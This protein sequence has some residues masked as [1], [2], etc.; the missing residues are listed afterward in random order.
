MNKKAITMSIGMIVMLIISV[1]IFIMAVTLLFKWFA[2]A[3]ELKAEIDR[4]TKEQIMQAL[5]IGNQLVAIP[6]AIQKTRRSNAVAFGIGVRNIKDAGDFSMAIRFSGAYTPEGREICKAG[7][8]CAEYIDEKWLGNFNVID[9][10]RLKKNE[11]TVKETSIYAHS[12]ISEGISTPRGDYAFN[13][14][15]YNQG[16]TARNEPPAA[17]NIGQFSLT[18]GG[19]FYTKKI[20]QVVLKII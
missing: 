6:V 20:Y 12:S 13:V 9:T 7:Q 17:C 14:C 16:L 10:F 19:D 5:R 8:T 1:L 2:G 11:Q 3:E 18:Q 15:V 4:Q